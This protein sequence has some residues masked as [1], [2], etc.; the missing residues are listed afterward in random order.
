MWQCDKGRGCW[1]FAVFGRIVVS[2]WPMKIKH[3]SLL[4]CK[5]PLIHWH[6]DMLQKTWKQVV[7]FCDSILNGW[8]DFSMMKGSASSN[9]SKVHVRNNE[10]GTV[11]FI[12]P[13]AEAYGLKTS[14]CKTLLTCY[15]LGISVKFLQLRKNGL[16]S[17]RNT[18]FQN[19]SGTRW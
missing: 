18:W 14:T 16:N 4:K 19:H 6:S 11:T 9:T 15:S 3:H 13:G 10:K 5:E 12:W 17:L 7:A 1:W 8:V 2:F